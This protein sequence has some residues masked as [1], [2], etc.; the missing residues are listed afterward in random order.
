LSQIAKIDDNLHEFLSALTSNGIDFACGVPDSLLSGLNKSLD[1]SINFKHLI[2]SNEGQALSIGIGYNL[3]TGKTPM[4]YLQNSGLGNLV[5]P[6]LSIAHADIFNIPIL[7]VIGWRG[8]FPNEDEPQ[9]RVQGIKT[10]D[11]LNFLDIP[12]IHINKE[13]EIYPNL[14]KFLKDS[15]IPG[16]IR[17][18]LVSKDTFIQN[19]T[20]DVDTDGLIREETIEFIYN[21]FTEESIFFATTGK[22]ARELFTIH[23]EKNFHKCFYV[24]GGMG[25]ASSI[26]LGYSSFAQNKRVIC[27]DGDGALLMQLGSIALIGDVEPKNFIHVLFDNKVHESVGGQRISNLGINYTKLFESVGYASVEVCSDI[28]QLN[29]ALQLSAS[30]NGLNA[31]IIKTNQ[32]SRKDLVRPH[33]NPALWKNQFLNDIT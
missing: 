6:L 17:A 18:I 2:A 16:N 26:A 13:S 11:T 21:F 30:N 33:G 4:I 9:H 20:P 10:R 32:R 27:L 28:T 8:E 24:I 7:L 5:N 23:H 25:H 19:N 3:R 15:R 29:D 1:S 12:Y 31:I 14:N 22:T